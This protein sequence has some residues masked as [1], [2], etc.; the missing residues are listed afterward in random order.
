[1]SPSQP[2]LLYYQSTMNLAPPQRLYPDRCSLCIVGPCTLPPETLPSAHQRLGRNIGGHFGVFLSEFGFCIGFGDELFS[3]GG[4]EAG[5]RTLVSDDR[6]L[7]LGSCVSVGFV[8]STVGFGQGLLGSGWS[9]RVL[10]GEAALLR[11]E[12]VVAGWT[13]RIFFSFRR[14]FFT[15]PLWFGL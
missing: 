13:S 4:L 15:P 1:M 14:F 11:L 2:K 8:A 7:G 9:L 10:R 3:G 12:V 6:V 5:K